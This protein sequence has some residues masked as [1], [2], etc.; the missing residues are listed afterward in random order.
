MIYFITC[1]MMFLQKI[2]K[3]HEVA[4]AKMTK[5]TLAAPACVYFAGFPRTA[6]KVLWKEVLVLKSQ[7]A[8]KNLH[9]R[10]NA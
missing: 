2:G 4:E 9:Q 3:N 7:T 5:N 8:G 10:M 6:W 1:S